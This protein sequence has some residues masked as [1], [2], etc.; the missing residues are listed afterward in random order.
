MTFK[1]ILA[2]ALAAVMA[3]A[4][5]GCAA[6]DE[7]KP[8]AGQNAPG[9]GSRAE[10]TDADGKA[11]YFINGS[12]VGSLENGVF[13]SAVDESLPWDDDR[14]YH[15]YSFRELFS[16]EYVCFERDSALGAAHEAAIYTGEGP[17][18][19]SEEK[20][21]TFAPYASRMEQ[22]CFA[23]L[24]LPCE[25][26]EDFA[27]IYAPEYGFYVN[28]SD[29][30]RDL[31]EYPALATNHRGACLPDGLSWD[32]GYSERDEAAIAR[33][34]ETAGVVYGE[35]DILTASGDFDSDGRTESVIFAGTAADAEGFLMLDADRSEVPFGLILYCD[36]NDEYE[37]VYIRTGEPLTDITSHFRIF[38]EGIFD[39]DGDGSFEIAASS[40]EWEWGSTFVLSRNAAGAWD[41]VMTAEWGN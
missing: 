24:P 38:P 18:G 40:H 28:I 7:K 41:T 23:V 2:A 31:S 33:A 15:R 19:F 32:N 17:G 39:L 11:Y 4:L 27:G 20:T 29:E 1:R 16:H 6:K 21:D 14:R 8:D 35:T 3:C 37:T 26:P 5:F 13:V 30:V 9:G 22:D 34:L 12:L 25:L 10:Y 36:D